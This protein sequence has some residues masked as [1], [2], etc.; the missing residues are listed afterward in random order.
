[1]TPL[2]LAALGLLAGCGGSSDD[3]RTGAAAPEQPRGPIE[4]AATDGR[5][6]AA[7]TAGRDGVRLL[8]PGGRI[9]PSG[10]RAPRRR[11]GVSAGAA[12]PDADV[13]PS[14]ETLG[15]VEAA[16]LCLVN[17]ERTAAGLGALEADDR[18]AAAAR[19]HAQA[20]VDRQ[21]FAHE[22]PDGDTSVD[23]IR[24][25]GYLPSGGAWLAGENLA[26]GT[27]TLASPRAIVDA[28]MRSSGHRE[29]ILRDRYR[30][31]GQG[32]VLGNPRSADGAGATYAMTFGAIEERGSGSASRPVSDERRSRS[33]GSRSRKAGRRAK[34]RSARRAQSRRA[35]AR[36][37][38][39]RR[40]RNRRASTRRRHRVEVQ[41][42]LAHRALAP[43]AETPR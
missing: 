33:R 3:P 13:R 31:L 7:T 6:G 32:I 4:L 35:A 17:A 36:R 25:T 26:W 19:R 9:D 43:G 24:A 40:A 30:E 5:T 15:A 18:L 39:K 14:A 34:A 20:M 27:G 10:V 16:T 42:V 37:A 21:F 8:S 1:M 29:N 38:A 41:R 22:G 23:R 2:L 28:W 12:C 11:D